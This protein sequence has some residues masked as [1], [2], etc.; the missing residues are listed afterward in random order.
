MELKINSNDLIHYQILLGKEI[1]FLGEIHDVLEEDRIL[2]Q[3]E[4]CF[5]RWYTINELLRKKNLP[6]YMGYKDL[7]EQIRSGRSAE[8]IKAKYQSIFIAE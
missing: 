2:D 7:I 5:F 3:Q 4:E 6:H 8:E 1:A